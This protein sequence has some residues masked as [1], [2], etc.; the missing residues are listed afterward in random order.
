MISIYLIQ[1][2]LRDISYKSFPLNN[3]YK[4]CDFIYEHYPVRSDLYL[5][6]AYFVS[7]VKRKPKEIEKASS[8]IARGFND[9]ASQSTDWILRLAP[10]DFRC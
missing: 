8:R 1:K 6:N 7:E 9:G 2:T 10:R 3:I 5:S 4:V